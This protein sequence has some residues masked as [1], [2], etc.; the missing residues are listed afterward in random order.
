ME[1][2]Q[3]LRQKRSKKKVIYKYI[4][5]SKIFYFSPSPYISAQRCK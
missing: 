1:I 2:E 4:T 5:I 3:E